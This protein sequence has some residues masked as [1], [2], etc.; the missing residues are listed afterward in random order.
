MSRSDEHPSSMLT[1]R[2][3]PQR[4]PVCGPVALNAAL[5]DRRL[6]PAALTRQSDQNR[7]V[8][9]PSWSRMLQDIAAAA[10]PTRDFRLLRPADGA[11]EVATDL[12][13]HEPALGL[14]LPSA[15][16]TKACCHGM[17]PGRRPKPALSL[18]IQTQLVQRG[19]SKA[20]AYQGGFADARSADRERQGSW[21]RASRT[22]NAADR[23]SRGETAIHARTSRANLARSRAAES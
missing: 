2:P 23:S 13:V 20:P 3:R 9:G 19:R 11:A 22:C 6:A 1:A 17:R 4:Q 5:C 16:Q 10:L 15:T 21:A 8:V 14:D 18:Q 7:A 12:M